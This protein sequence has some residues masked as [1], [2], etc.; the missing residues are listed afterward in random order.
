MAELPALLTEIQRLKGLTRG[1]PPKLDQAEAAR[2]MG[3]QQS[4]LYRYLRGAKPEDD[5]KARIAI[6]LE[7][8]G[9]FLLG[10]GKRF[11]DMTTLQ[12]LAHMALDRYLEDYRKRDKL[13]DEDADGLR[14]VADRHPNPPLWS[15]VWRQVHTTLD[16]S[17]RRQLTSAESTP[18]Q[19]RPFQGRRGRGRYTPIA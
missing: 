10:L 6:G 8:D 16:L 17:A 18:R 4:Q 11:K 1:D 9:N 7:L 19:P 13:S 12:A 2:L 14:Y 3:I 15:R 5:A